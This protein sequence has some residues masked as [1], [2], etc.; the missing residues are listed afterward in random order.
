MHVCVHTQAGRHMAGLGRDTN[1]AVVAARVPL[2]PQKSALCYSYECI[3]DSGPE[4][5]PN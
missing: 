2:G 3:N 4:A 1:A 5:D